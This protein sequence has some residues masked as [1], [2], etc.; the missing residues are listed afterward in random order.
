MGW[1]GQ[2]GGGGGRAA[3]NLGY[4]PKALLCTV[5]LSGSADYTHLGNPPLNAGPSPWLHSGCSLS[6][7]TG[8]LSGRRSSLSQGKNEDTPKER[9]EVVRSV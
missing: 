2:R 4:L 3:R 5:G 6:F 9:T 1:S 7:L 8:C